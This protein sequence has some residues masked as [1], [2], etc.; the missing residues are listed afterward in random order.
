MRW[1]VLGSLEVVSA[2]RSVPLGPPQQRRLLALLVLWRNA[3]VATDQLVDALWEEEAPATAGKA[4]QVYVSR[5]RKVLPAGCLTT[6][7]RSYRLVVEAGDLDLDVFAA[8]CAEARAARG[9]EP[10]RAIEAFDRALA[11]WRGRCLPEL[12]GVRTVAGD[13]AHLEEERLRAIED[14]SQLLLEAGDAERVTMD[15]APVVAAEPLRERPRAQL[16]LALYRSGR[17]AEALDVFREGRRVLVEQLGIEPS[18]E[19]RRLHQAILEQDPALGGGRP[20]PAARRGRRRGRALAVAAAAVVVTGTVLATGAERP[21]PLRATV[22]SIVGLDPRTGRIVHVVPTGSTPVGAAAAGG[23]LWVANA[24][25]RTVTRIDPATGRVTATIGIEGEASAIAAGRDAVWVAGAATGHGTGT[26]TRIDAR[27]RTT[28]S[29]VVRRGDGGNHYAPPSPTALAVAGDRVWANHLGQR[30]VWV[31]EG[32]EA[33]LHYADLGPDRSTD[34]VVATREGVWVSSAASARVVL[35]DAEGRIRREVPLPAEPGREAAPFALAAGFGAL[36][37]A[38]PQGG[39]VVRVEGGRATARVRVGGRPTRVATGAGAVWA[40]DRGRGV[41]VRVDPT[42]RVVTAR[43]RVHPATTNIAVAGGKLWATVGGGPGRSAPRA[44]VAGRG[45]TTAACRPPVLPPGVRAA[46][47]VAVD[48]PF[49]IAGRA[50][51]ETTLMGEAVLQAVRERGFRAGRH[52]VG[53]QLC[54]SS[55]RRSGDTDPERCAQNARAY[56]RTPEVLAVIGPYQSFCAALQLATLNTTDTGPLATIT[57]SATDPGLTR[58]APGTA[59]DDPERHRPSGVPSFAR[60]IVADHRRG[61]AL[62]AAVRLSG[63][64]RLLALHS[65]DRFFADVAEAA[66]RS[67]RSAG[68]SVAGT[69]AWGPEPR[70]LAD[71]RAALRRARPDVVLLSGCMC[72]GAPAVLRAIRDELGAGAVVLAP[73]AALSA[74]VSVGEAGSAALG[75]RFVTPGTPAPELPPTGRAFLERLRA[76]TG[77]RGRIGEFVATAAAASEVALAAIGSSDGTRPS[78]TRQLLR[79]RLARSVIGPIA[80][81][82]HGDLRQASY[83]V[84]RIDRVVSSPE[85][86]RFRDPLAD[87]GA[88]AEAVVRLPRVSGG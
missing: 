77:H 15:L 58:S 34:A 69:A 71:V 80:F 24:G 29:F 87:Q 2:G 5:L 26:L 3:P 57:P 25:D 56:A 28:E 9:R 76:R 88:T 38:D 72:Q 19:L 53:V 86:G 14:R 20:L 67:A 83:G 40:L 59:V 85:R 30:L 73:D 37:V 81:D 49:Q 32:A 44:P 42:S 11:L 62:A 23:A 6:E 48:L 43:V 84:W 7:G 33:P 16:M 18:P 68:V 17:Q 82:E 4:V 39:A 63:G 21:P 51:E 54:D 75:L 27:T 36:W 35:V 60:T 61:E 22:D 70:R 64:R 12:D 66:S 45:V 47:I 52:R 1:R 46:P 50:H 10:A 41:V 31:G 8:C 13:R 79:V 78:V 74:S 55:T 65:G